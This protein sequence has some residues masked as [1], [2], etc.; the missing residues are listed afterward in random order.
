MERRTPPSAMA[1]KAKS[2][3]MCQMVVVGSGEG[4]NWRKTVSSE[5][6]WELQKLV[7]L[8]GTD[9]SAVSGELESSFGATSYLAENVVSCDACGWVFL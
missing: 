3:V 9:R 5:M 6:P 2:S 8:A 4:V 7:R 1:V